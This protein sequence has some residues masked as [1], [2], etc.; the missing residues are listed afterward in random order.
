MRG[1]MSIKDTPGVLPVVMVISHGA[2]GEGAYLASGTAMGAP[3]SELGQENTDNDEVFVVS[4]IRET[5]DDFALPLTADDVLMPLAAR[6]DIKSPRAY[7][8]DRLREALDSSSTV[9]RLF[10]RRPR[11]VIGFAGSE[12][13]NVVS[14]YAIIS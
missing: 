7:T 9:S 2:N 13:Q 3:T 14:R 6:G 8:N 12:A 11:V 10:L 5:F 1:S 4:E